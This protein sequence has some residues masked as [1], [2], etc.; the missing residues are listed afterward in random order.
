MNHFPLKS[1]S[2]KIKSLPKHFYQ[3]NQKCIAYPIISTGKEERWLVEYKKGFTL[4]K[5]RH[6]Y[7]RYELYVIYGKIKYND[8]E[9]GTYHILEKDSYYFNPPNFLHSLETLEDSKVLWIN[10]EM[11]DKN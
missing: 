2:V 3:N 5:H 9:K 1:L 4:D 10:T 6:P 8:D 11:N 7:G